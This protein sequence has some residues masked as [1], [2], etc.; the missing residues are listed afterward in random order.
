MPVSGAQH[1]LTGTIEV[2]LPPDEAFRLF[3]PRGEQDWV[4]GWEP[5]FPAAVVDDSAPGTVFE[6]HAHGEATTWV[7]VDRQRGRRI[8][9]AC[10]R[11]RSR[12]GAVTV[13]L[14]AAADHSTV[15]VTYELTAL[16]R[17][18]GQELDEF[19]ANFPALL[20]SWENAIAACLRRT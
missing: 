12:A 14:E 2:P 5:H 20:R 15:H 11:G 16:V 19:A 9:Y 10:V 13:V 1:Q 4:K 6:T 8:S 3:T 7:V 18:A 17:A